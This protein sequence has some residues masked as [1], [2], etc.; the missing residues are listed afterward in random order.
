MRYALVEFREEFEIVLNALA[1]IRICALPIA[2]VE[3]RV[4]LYAVEL[5][6][7]IPQ[8]VLRLYALRIKALQV[9]AVPFRTADPNLH[10]LR[11]FR[12]KYTLRRRMICRDR[13]VNLFRICY[14]SKFH[15]KYQSSPATS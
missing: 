13:K 8:L 7:V 2:L 3:G 15:K 11:L 4:Q 14:L 6:R 1:P 10:P 12:R 5:C 9:L